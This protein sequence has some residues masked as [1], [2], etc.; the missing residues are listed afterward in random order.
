MDIILGQEDDIGNDNA[1]PND[2]N[3]ELA[4]EYSDQLGPQNTQEL[5]QSIA[6]RIRIKNRHKLY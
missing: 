5:N 4:I 2:L 1:T 3:D 6:K